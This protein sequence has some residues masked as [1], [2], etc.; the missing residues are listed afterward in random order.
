MTLTDEPTLLTATAEHVATN[1]PRTATATPTTTAANPATPSP[2]ASAATM[3]GS[4]VIPA[5]DEEAVILRTLEGLRPLIEQRVVEVVVACN[6]CSDR[7]AELA[8]SVDGVTVL[9][10]PQPLKTAA[11]NAADAAAEHW[12]RLYLDADIAITADAA[13]EVLDAVSRGDALAARPEFRYVM[14]SASAPVRA[15]YRARDRLPNTRCGLWGAGAFALGAEGRARFGEFPR[16]IADDVF[17]DRH[18]SD[19][20][21]RIV[22][23]TPV[24]VRVPQRVRN[25]MAVLRR[26][27]RGAGQ[28]AIRT[29]GTAPSTM[30]QL[31][32]SVRGPRSAVDA[33]VYAAL[34]AS[35]RLPA[36]R[37]RGGAVW[38]RDESTRVVPS[39][40]ATASA[41][42][43]PAASA[44]AS[45]IAPSFAGPDDAV[46][47]AAVVVTYESRPCIDGLLDSLRREAG[48]HT[49][50]AIVADNASADGTL[51]RVRERHPDVV[52]IGTGANLGYAGAINVAAAS[53]GTARAI[54]VLNPDAVVEPGAVDAMLRRLDSSGAGAVVPRIRDADGT[55]YESLRREPS[56]MGAIG[57]ALFGG[58]LR[59][60]PARLSEMVFD[61]RA[62]GHAHPVD[63][64]T[65]AAVLI[66]AR[67]AR[68]IGPWDERYFLYSEET[69][70]LRRLRAT[71]ANVWYEPA[72]VVTHAQGGSGTSPALHAL[73]AVNRIR[74]AQK[75]RSA[76]YAAAFRTVAVLAE[77]L[78]V[79]RPHHEGVLAIVADSRRWPGLPRA[80]R[81]DD[82]STRPAEGR[83]T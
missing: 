11:L 30:R 44:A 53:I 23:T 34:S 75:F 66:D 60:R 27:A 22:S 32:R 4:I 64:A 2:S 28:L 15:Y 71:G 76:P 21:K 81:R 3:R 65:G 7:T 70:Y 13:L 26:Q 77:L 36:L 83:V 73:E 1:R 61:Q 82:D 6:G 25:L 5:H 43:R 37:A 56:L 49:I 31:V 63:W 72:A 45:G 79:G 17:V 24:P 10:T 74:Y 67:V 41:V 58:R 35:S 46:D 57:D 18:F 16:V 38:E 78:R 52:A 50:R 8:A 68:R 55:T 69:D 80:P 39:A 14:D 54:L 29:T 42:A 9:Q 59:G 20:E 40:A 48:A 12:P 47:L 19:P 51:D 33:A 62:Y